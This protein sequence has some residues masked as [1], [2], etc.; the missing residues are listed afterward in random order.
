MDEDSVAEMSK[1][2]LTV[3]TPDAATR[4]A[5]TQEMAEV[6]P[7]LRGDYCPADIYDEVLSLRDEYRASR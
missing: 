2:G 6:Y 4:R 7:R 5:W 3:N 1:R